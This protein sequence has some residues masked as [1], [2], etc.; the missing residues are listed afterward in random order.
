[1]KF[2][3]FVARRYL[4][5]KKS[6]NAINIIS[7]ISVAGVAIGTMA[8]VV[9]LS[10]FNGIEELVESLY[11]SFDPDIEIST[12]EGKSFLMNDMPV[13]AI[14]ALPNVKYIGPMIEESALLTHGNEQVITRMR[15]LTKEQL[16]FNGIDSSITTGR[17]HLDGEEF[18]F[19][20][21][22]M[23]IRHGLALPMMPD[24]VEPVKFYVPLRGKSLRKDRESAFNQKYLG[25]AAEFS[26]NADLDLSYTLVPYEFA[27]DLL[28]YEDRV[29]AYQIALHKPEEDET[30]RE[31]IMQILGNA[32]EVKTRAQQNELL[33]KT[34]RTE[35]W[36]TFM[37]LTF[38]LVIATFN[39][40]ASLTMLVID[41]K[42]DMAILTSM[43]CDSSRMRLI[44]FL[45][46]MLIN[47]F[48]AGIGLAL[49]LLLC[50][51]QEVVGLVPL[52]GTIVDYYPVSVELPDLLL[53]SGTV[54]VIG[55]L[56]S[57]LPIRYLV[58]K[59][60]YALAGLVK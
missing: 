8:L 53:I 1:M 45:Q 14:E 18:D 44:F 54:L 11:K 49:G 32:Y 4:F 42:R 24:M 19:A 20:I 17:E 50:F 12:M 41:K 7:G 60:T 55:F 25:G 57:W 28:Q 23:G 27:R 37:I 2:P 33:Y 30:T 52:D 21:L 6:H 13:S 31:E 26:I 46:G 43:G 36:F 16:K 47:L 5:S 59:H 29:T 22:G 34:S 35:K 9:I 40:I 56:A 10:A 48:G 39:I 15:G 51:L 3:F 58:Q 38:I